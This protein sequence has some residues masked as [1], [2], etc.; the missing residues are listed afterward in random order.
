MQKWEYATRYM[1]RHL[2]LMFQPKEWENNCD[3]TKM[4]LEGW[5][6]VSAV[7]VASHGGT[8]KCGLTTEIYFYFKR[9]TE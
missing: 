6:L 1:K 4:G 9:P 5:E 2:S 3:L 8:P 7:P